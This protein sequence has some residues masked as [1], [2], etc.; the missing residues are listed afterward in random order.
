MKKKIILTIF[1]GTIALIFIMPLL[2][3]L[4]NSFM[5]PN[6]VENQY[7]LIIKG[8]ESDN[9]GGLKIIPNWISFKQYYQI[10][11]NKPKYLSLFWNS[12]FIVCPIIIGQIIVS[13]FAA[14]GFSKIKFRYRNKIFYFYIFLMLMPFQVVAVPNYLILKFLGLINKFSSII[15][16]G[17]FSVFGVFLLRQF[18]LKI[19]DEYVEAAKID[20]ANHL[21]ILFKV[22]IPLSKEYIISLCILILIDYW[23]MVEQPL[24]FLRDKDKYPL[25]LFLAQTTSEEMKITFAASIIYLLPVLLIFL[26]AEK[27]FVEGIKN[28]GMKG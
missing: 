6:E 4:F 8:I 12:V 27:Y 3:T 25:S 28:T 9:F 20:G 11:I 26:Y 24:V 15:F 13:L 17:I 10:L 18:M 1:I 7:N 22:I 2:I 14:Y 23:N 5:E 16:P 19:P 21:K